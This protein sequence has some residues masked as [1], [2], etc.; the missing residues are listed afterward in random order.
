MT[1]SSLPVQRGTKSRFSRNNQ[2]NVVVVVGLLVSIALGNGNGGGGGILEGLLV[3]WITTTGRRSRQ[4]IPLRSRKHP[5][6]A[7]GSW[8][9]FIFLQNENTGWS[10]P[11]MIHTLLFFSLT[12]LGCQSS[13]VNKKH[14]NPITFFQQVPRSGIFTQIR[15]V[16]A[17]SGALLPLRGIPNP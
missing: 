7:P 3:R 11:W 1:F 17:S 10:P 2:L 13:Q 5:G 14:S 8:I 15:P 12:F 6:L 4:S 16:K 9:V